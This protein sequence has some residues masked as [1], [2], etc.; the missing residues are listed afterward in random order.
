LKELKTNCPE[1]RDTKLEDCPKVCF[2]APNCN[3][4]LGNKIGDVLKWKLDEG[5][6]FRTTSS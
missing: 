6:K 5:E 3:V 2:D 1:K 4:D